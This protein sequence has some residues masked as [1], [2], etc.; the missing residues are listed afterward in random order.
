MH[1]YPKETTIFE[2]ERGLANLNPKKSKHETDKPTKDLK[3]NIHVFSLFLL[4]YFTAEHKSHILAL[5]EH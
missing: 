5:R 2:I 1:Q 4:N 3:E